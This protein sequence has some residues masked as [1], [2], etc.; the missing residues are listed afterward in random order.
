MLLIE[1]DMGFVM[2][3]ADSVVVLCDGRLLAQGSPREVRQD[4]RVI[5]AYL[6]EVVQ[7]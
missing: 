7:L 5:E 2:G 4:R 3:L 1:H 6:G